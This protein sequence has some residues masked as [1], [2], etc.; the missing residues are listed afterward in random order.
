MAT[1]GQLKKA[2]EWVQLIQK[3]GRINK[4]DL[5]DK[6]S[7]SIATYNQSKPYIEHRYG[8]YVEYEKSSKDWIKK[9]V[10]ETE[11]SKEMVKYES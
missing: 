11:A 6:L 1:K 8:H 9:E 7:I 4:F 2:T 3:E 5:M 10:T